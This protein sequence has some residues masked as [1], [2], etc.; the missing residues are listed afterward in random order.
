MQ[1]VAR[2]IQR[3]SHNE[4]IQSQR[5]FISDWQAAHPTTDEEQAAYKAML[6]EAEAEIVAGRKGGEGWL[7]MKLS[8]EKYC[9]GDYEH[10][11]A[12]YFWVGK[13]Q[14]PPMKWTKKDHKKFIKKRYPN[15]Y[16]HIQ[17][18]EAEKKRG[19]ILERRRRRALRL[20]RKGK[21]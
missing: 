9:P 18:L 16:P 4:A 8:E 21:Y 17:Q 20:R 10:W 15:G 19:S 6:E 3:V 5:D 1:R 2:M 11:L 7:D 13:P 12:E 14:A